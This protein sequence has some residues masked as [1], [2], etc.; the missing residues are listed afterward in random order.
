MAARSRKGSSIQ[1]PR[2]P[3]LKFP[4]LA[5]SFAGVA[6]GGRKFRVGYPIYINLPYML[7][8]VGLTI[9]AIDVDGAVTGVSQQYTGAVSQT[10]G[11]ATF[12]AQSPYGKGLSITV[13]YTPVP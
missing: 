7:S 3:S 8:P 6:T 1:R 10:T 13:S 2:S 4:Y 9:T 12:P 11:V 5:V